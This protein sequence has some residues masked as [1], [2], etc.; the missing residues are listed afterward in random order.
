MV[1]SRSP[2]TRFSRR[3]RS[4]S[5]A[6]VRLAWVPFDSRRQRR[7]TSKATGLT[8]SSV[9]PEGCSDQSK[10]IRSSILDCQTTG[11]T[12]TQLVP[13]RHRSLPPWRMGASA[14]MQVRIKI[15]HWSR[16]SSRTATVSCP[17]V[18]SQMRCRS[19]SALSLVPIGSPSSE[20]PRMTAPHGACSPCSHLRCQMAGGVLVGRAAGRNAP[21]A[22]PPA[23]FLL[24]VHALQ[25]DA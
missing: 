22:G 13:T 4:A 10:P 2:L 1:R 19:Q 5:V 23:S 25:F 11:S 7:A 18:S 16:L 12:S 6:S 17:D 20:T 14:S 24:E 21:I 3:S 8:S 9:L 15:R